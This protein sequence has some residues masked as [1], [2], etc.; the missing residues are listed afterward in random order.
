MV[1]ILPF[2]AQPATT[3]A[4]YTDPAGSQAQSLPGRNVYLPT[5]SLLETRAQETQTKQISGFQG[6]WEAGWLRAAP[7]HAASFPKR[8]LA[9]LHRPWVPVLQHPTP[10]PW[11]GS[12]K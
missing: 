8:T 4:L 2:N 11:V 3:P 9:E 12:D 5:C 6:E 7:P 1:Y 10:P